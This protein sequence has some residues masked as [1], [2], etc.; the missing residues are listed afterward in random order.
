ML[1]RVIFRYHKD[2]DVCIQNLKNLRRMNP[3]V[4]IDGL[5]GGD[6]AAFKDIPLELTNLLTT[7]WCIPVDDPFYKWKNGDLCVRWWFREIGVNLDFDYVMLIEWDLYT[8]KPLKDIYKNIE[9][10]VNY[11][12][13][14][15]DYQ[16]AKS[17]DWYWINN[18]YKWEIE[19]LT[20]ALEKNN[21]TFEMEK[22]SFGLMGGSILCRKFLERLSSFPIP[23][24]SNDEFRLSVYSQ[25]F[26]IPLL[27]NG[28]RTNPSNYIDADDCPFDLN[29]YKRIVEK[30]GDVIH[31]VR[32]IIND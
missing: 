6:I 11:F 2:F 15:G 24:Y 14:F 1:S 19:N 18:H 20:N 26:G 12:T 22:L 21:L 5:Y 28:L 31:P 8:L 30:N 17:I 29:D 16:Y 4:P 32:F 25:A 27:D 7:N 23:S 3:D 13:R 9:R 10:H